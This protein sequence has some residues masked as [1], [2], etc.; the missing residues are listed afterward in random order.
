M[1][2]AVACAVQNTEPM[3]RPLWQTVLSILIAGAAVQRGGAAA[4]AFGDP[5]GSAL[6]LPLAVETL[7]LAAA[8]SGLFLGGRAALFGAPALGVGLAAGALAA[9]VLVGAPAAPFAVGRL[10]VAVVGAA[11][12]SY[13]VRKEL[14]P[15]ARGGSR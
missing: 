6:A 3:D 13:V 1:R 4:I 14:L 9:L 8:A 2:A 12:L 10:A 11:G 15:F 5:Q 7:A